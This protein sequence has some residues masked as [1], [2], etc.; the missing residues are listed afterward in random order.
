[1]NHSVKKDF[2]GC[3]WRINEKILW[4]VAIIF[5]WM[6]HFLIIWI[7]CLASSAKLF[8]FKWD[9]TMELIKQIKD[10]EKQAK[11]IV[12]KARQDAVSLL[13]EAKKQRDDQLKQ[14]Q[15]RRIQSIE[16]SVNRAEQDGKTQTD[17]ISQTG[18]EEISALDEST[19]AKIQACVEKVLS[20]L[21]QTS[22]NSICNRWKCLLV[23]RVC[24]NP[25]YLSQDQ[26][27]IW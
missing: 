15:Q 24:E 25:E 2:L 5:C 9:D 17:Q 20:Q 23:L 14:S 1:M 19:S 22:W 16:D 8:V 3:C 26:W 6:F 13:E 21:Q 11:D 12:E 4:T 7:A 10:S 27:L 18:S